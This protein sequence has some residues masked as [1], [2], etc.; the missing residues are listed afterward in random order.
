MVKF[1]Y[2]VVAVFL[3]ISLFVGCGDSKPA[4]VERTAAQAQATQ[5]VSTEVELVN[6]PADPALPTWILVVEPFGMGASGVTANTGQG[7]GVVAVAHGGFGGT[8][9][10]IINSGVVSA[11]VIN[12]GDQ[13]G[14]GV[15]AQLISSLQKVGNVVVVDYA[16]YQANPSQVAAGLQAG[17]S[18]PFLVKGTVTEFS[19]TADA[20][21][22]GKSRGP[23]LWAL[24][25]PYAGPVIALADGGKSSSQ[26]RHTGM[27]GLDIQIVDPKTGRLVA[28]FAASGSFVSLSQTRSRTRWGRTEVTT[29]YASSAI[30]QAQRIALNKAVAEIHRTLARQKLL[31]NR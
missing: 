26:T 18:G 25:V 14:P 4:Q 30:G 15:S 11:P 29:D 6:I 1:V 24:F 23:N 12:P 22:Q 3:F 28:S 13:I 31:A 27:V 7:G 21:G 16:T 17:E 19:E 2:L 9:T 8:Q 5:P 10:Q 20:S